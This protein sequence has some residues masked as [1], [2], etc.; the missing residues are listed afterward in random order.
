MAEIKILNPESLGKHETGSSVA[1]PVFKDFM[2][3]A[4]KDQPPRA[5]GDNKAAATRIASS[6]ASTSKTFVNSER[7]KS[8]NFEASSILSSVGWKLSRIDF[9]MALTILSPIIKIPIQ[10]ENSRE[11]VVNSLERAIWPF[12]RASRSRLGVACSVLSCPPS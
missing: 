9:R 7:K 2:G 10:D 5:I 3:E 8:G 12:S 1:V 11:N 6:G 4:L